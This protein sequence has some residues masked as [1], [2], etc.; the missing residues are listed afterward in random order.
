MTIHITSAHIESW[1]TEIESRSLLPV[2]VRRLIHS[3]VDHAN[4]VKIDFPGDADTTSSRGYDGILEC[5][6]TNGWVPE[7]I[8]VWE[9]STSEGVERKANEDYQKR[10]ADPLKINPSTTTYIGVSTRKWNG[11]NDWKIARR[12][13]NIWRDVRFYDADDLAQWMETSPAISLWMGE[14]IGHHISIRGV[15]LLENHW[16]N[17]CRMVKDG[18]NI[19]PELFTISRQ[20]N[21][22][23]LISWLRN[24]PG[25]F[26]V[27]SDSDAAVL[28]FIAAV[29]ESMDASEKEDY[30]SRALVLDQQ[31]DWNMKFSIWGVLLFSLQSPLC[32]SVWSRTWYH[33]P[34]D[35]VTMFYEFRPNF[36]AN[37]E[38]VCHDS[39]AMIYRPSLSE[40]DTRL[41]MPD[42]W[43]KK[44]VVRE[45]IF[46]I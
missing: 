37:P 44:S 19:S 14:R 34:C 32:L 35:I 1:S 18:I 46:E 24:P 21:V 30:H 36:M 43:P 17:V 40:Q 6:Q 39:T 28:D 26:P 41:L 9:L 20:E 22:T 7:G 2:F 25:D 5:K 33:R 27:K 11:K 15:S 45:L 12:Q 3:T 10:T 38:C 16:P 4:I 8:S 23:A 31:V 42:K 29:I 13:E